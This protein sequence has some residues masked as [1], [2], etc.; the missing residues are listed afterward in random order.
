MCTYKHDFF[1]SFTAFH[2][3]ATTKVPETVFPTT[4]GPATNAPTTSDQIV[5]HTTTVPFTTPETGTVINSC[6]T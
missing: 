3:A 2:S 1:S 5:T 6:Q 4:P